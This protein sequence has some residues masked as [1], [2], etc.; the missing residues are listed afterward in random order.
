MGLDL[1]LTML[2]FLFYSVRRTWK[3]MNMKCLKYYTLL[4]P[5]NTIINF[6]KHKS[7]APMCQYHKRIMLLNYGKQFHTASS[8]CTVLQSAF[9]HM[10]STDSR[11]SYTNQENISRKD[12]LEGMFQDRKQKLAESRQMILKDIKEKKDKMKEKMEEVIEKENVLTIPNLLCLFRIAAAPYLGYLVLQSEFHLAVAI[13]AFAGVTDLVDGWIARTYPS[14]SSKFGS[15]LDPLAD[16]V[17]IACLFLTL[18]YAGYIPIALTGMI[19]ARD[20]LLVAAGFYIRYQ[21]LPPPKTLSRYFDATHVTAQLAPT[22]VS[23]INT[24]IQLLLACSTLAA[25][26]FDY[27]DH[28]FLHGLWYLTAGTTAASAISYIISQ[29]TYKYFRIKK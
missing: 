27:V 21:S 5:E 14:Q 20:I 7:N 19:I 29:D 12:F 3:P 26:V 28:P 25:P 23:K 6:L 2:R 18:T 11:K 15:F 8:L 13:F 22:Y 9:S 4:V 10:Y 16:K 1:W 24:A 17:L